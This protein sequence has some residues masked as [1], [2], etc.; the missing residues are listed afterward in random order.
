MR[1]SLLTKH[2]PTKTADG[3]GGSTI[4]LGT[5]ETMWGWVVL[6][7]PEEIYLTYRHGTDLKPEDVV[8][9]EGAQYRV[10]GLTGNQGAPWC[11][12]VIERI[13]KPVVPV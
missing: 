2:R 6:H 12:A 1:P 10:V 5:G 4:A 11:R 8:V 13:A 3:E 7:S 9:A